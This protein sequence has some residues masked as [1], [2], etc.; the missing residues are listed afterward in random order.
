MLPYYWSFANP[1][2]EINGASCFV[3][4]GNRIALGRAYFF[5]WWNDAIYCLPLIY[6]GSWIIKDRS[7]A[8]RYH[9]IFFCFR[10]AIICAFFHS[11]GRV[12]V[13]QT[14]LKMLRM[15]C[16]ELELR[17]FITS[18]CTLSYP[19]EGGAVSS[20]FRLLKSHKN[21][22]LKYWNFSHV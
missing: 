6:K 18:I 17:F 10:R 3:G 7:I 20:K 13:F 1:L 21:L 15:V 22:I 19:A 4:C 2:K 9:W 12:L 11:S 8:W 5:L 14:L 16:L